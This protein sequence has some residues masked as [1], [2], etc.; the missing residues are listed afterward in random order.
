MEEVKERYSEVIEEEV[1]RLGEETVT[2][3]KEGIVSFCKYLKSKGYNFLS[4]LTG[5]DLGAGKDPRFEVIYHLTM[6]PSGKRLRVKVRLSAGDPSVD[7]VTCVWAGANWFEREA[8]DMLGIEFRGHPELS[9]ILTPE[10]FE[11]HPLRKDY[12]LRGR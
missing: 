5:V 11:G 2:V 3:R 1:E 8:Y 4:D 9:R 6:I 7:S 10:G 12:P